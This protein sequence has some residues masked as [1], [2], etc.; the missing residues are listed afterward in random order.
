MTADRFWWRRARIVLLAGAVAALAGCDDG[1]DGAANAKAAP[2]PPEVTVAKPLIRRL[3]EWDEFTGRFEPVQQVDIRARVAGY[4]QEIGFEDG[5][6]VE[7]GQML[8]VIDPRPYQAA[9]DRA[10]AQIDT[11]HAQLDLARLDQER[12]SRLVSTS[13]VAKATLDDRNAQ[14]AEASANLA[15]SEAA[16]RQAELDLGFTRV[17]A[18][19]AGR[20]SDRRVDVGNL[21]SDATL[22]TTIVQLDPI[23]LSFDMSESDFLAY[24]RA[25]ARGELPSTRD[26]RTIVH[27]H[28]VDED[29]WPHEGTMSFVDNVVDQGSGTIRGR[30][31]F[32]NP[33]GLVTPG[34]FGRIRIP[35]SPEYDAVVIP[36]A[37]IVTD[38]ARKLVLTVGAD[39]VVTPK[40]IRPGP[41]Q[42]GG[43]RIVRRGLGA[44]DTLVIN[45]LIRARPG[46]KV[47][48]KQGEIAPEPDE[49]AAG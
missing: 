3:T 6:Q 36:D 21:V 5:A 12:A 1:G 11:Q 32:P 39:G 33:Q 41:S 30:A 13:A 35:G 17:T 40:I 7:A 47:S 4:V 8:F 48:P 49:P 26:N 20:V 10:K 27:A 23:Y 28:L 38:Q 18:P 2:P 19:F 22:L 31:T 42:P 16:L 9:V 25:S 15:A 34:Q 37:A 46:A 45:G 43:L 14:L 24:Q 44:D 29:G